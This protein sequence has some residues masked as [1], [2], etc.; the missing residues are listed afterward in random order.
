MSI[1]FGDGRMK[2][3]HINL[4]KDLVRALDNIAEEKGISRSEVIRRALD[5]WRE[6]KENRQGLKQKINH[7]ES[8]D[9]KNLNELEE[10][11][12]N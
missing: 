2:K 3:I 4:N 10:D 7:I 1:S 5:R 6:W 11:D 12:G 9:T 8:K